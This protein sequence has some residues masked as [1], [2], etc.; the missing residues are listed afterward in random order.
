MPVTGWPDEF[1]KVNGFVGSFVPAAQFISDQ[2]VRCENRHEKSTVSVVVVDAEPQRQKQR[3][4]EQ[5]PARYMGRNTQHD[6]M[7]GRVWRCGRVASTS[8]LTL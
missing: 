1:T 2:R 3:A 4:I 7:G 8:V 5:P 6:S